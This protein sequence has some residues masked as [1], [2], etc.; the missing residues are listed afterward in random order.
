MNIY[1]KKYIKMLAHDIQLLNNT[2]CMS[3]GTES[4]IF[5]Y[6]ECHQGN[7]KEEITSESKIYNI[8][9]QSL[10]VIWY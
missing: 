8:Y 4:S 7:K 9:A 3:M 1:F 10:C 5:K 6:Q 2:S